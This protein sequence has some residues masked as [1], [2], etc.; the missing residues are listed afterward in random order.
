MSYKKEI[1]KLKYFYFKIWRGNE[2]PSP[3]FN[4]EI[5]KITWSGWRHITCSPK[6]S[7]CEVLERTKLLM[8]AKQLLEESTFIQTYRQEENIEY[9]SLQGLFN[10]IPVRA[11]VRSKNK[12]VKHLYSIFSPAVNNKERK[13]K[14]AK[15]SPKI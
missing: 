12:G 7:R 6:R 13:N 14:E 10:D 3:A 4:N 5:V 8:Y 9:W 1:Y 2:R 15:K 11:I